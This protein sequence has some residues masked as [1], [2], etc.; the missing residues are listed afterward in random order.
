MITRAAL[1]LA[2]IAISVVAVSADSSC[3]IGE[4]CRVSG[5]I[6]IYRTPPAFTAILE[7]DQS[8]IPL[9]LPDAVYSD[10]DSWNGKRVVLRGEALP[11]YSSGG[12]VLTYETRGRDVIASLCGDS[13]YAL[14]VNE[15]TLADQAPAISVESNESG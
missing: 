13:P 3:D 10:A 15:I 14:F 5:I 11:N 8:C 7:I 2:L 9:A 4:D 12:G 6:S 1:F